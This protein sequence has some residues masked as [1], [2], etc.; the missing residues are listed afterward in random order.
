MEE[1][2]DIA[3]FKQLVL[4]Q[5]G[6]EASISRSLVSLLTLTQ[7]NDDNRQNEYPRIMQF[8]VVR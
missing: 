1:F 3:G 6:H 7:F 2:T 8:I 5:F 4:G